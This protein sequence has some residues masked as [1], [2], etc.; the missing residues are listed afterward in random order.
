MDALLK[1]FADVKSRV[2]ELKAAGKT[3]DTVTAQLQKEIPLRYAN[4]DNPEWIKNLVQK[5][6]DMR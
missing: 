2:G 3:L 6:Y 1:Y 5:F 4:W